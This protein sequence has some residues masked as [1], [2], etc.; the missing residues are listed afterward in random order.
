MDRLA[1]L[2]VL[3]ALAAI[4]VLIGHVIAEAEHYFGLSLPGDII[5]WT[6]GVD[7]FFVIS[8]FIVALSASRFQGRP[9]AFLFR[10]LH[11]VVPLYWLFTTLMVLVVLLMPSG[12]KDTVA[13][14]AQIFTSYLFIPWERADGR[15]APVLSLGWTL[16]Y[17]MAFY[18]ILSAALLMRRSLTVVAV[19]LVLL[20]F[21]GKIAEPHFAPVAAWTNPIILE[22]LFGIVLARMWQAGWCRPG[23][24]GSLTL[25]VAGLA[26][27]VALDGSGLPRVLSAGLP[28][29]VLVAAGTLFCP[30]RPLPF[31]LVGDASYALYLSHRFAL[32]GLTLLVLPLLPGTSAG[33]ALF[34][35]IAIMV[36]IAVGIGV[37]LWVER[38]M[39]AAR[40]PPRR[41]RAA[42]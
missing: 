5:P 19:A 9:G 7:I 14:T 28:A 35:V 23:M 24:A 34:C 2:Q 3:R 22:F 1:G 10:R 42:A 11:R 30:R 20:V 21:T 40:L 17:E 27:L 39:L 16:N 13:D 4:M 12:A 38:P 37:H 33:A 8:G 36:S 15:I 26:L 6:R 29:T 32:R 25:G 18:V 41:E 31:Q